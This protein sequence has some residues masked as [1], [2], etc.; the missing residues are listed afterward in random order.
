VDFPNLDL[1]NNVTNTSENLNDQKSDSVLLEDTD[2]IP[3][4]I[5]TGNVSNDS[6]DIDSTVNSILGFS[7]SSLSPHVVSPKIR[8]QNQTPT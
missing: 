3:L 1:S 7:T 2:I 5:S 8:T 4:D 6:V